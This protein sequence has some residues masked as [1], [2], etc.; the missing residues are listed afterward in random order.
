[1][2]AS[3]KIIVSFLLCVV[4]FV[5]FGCSCSKSINVESVV[6]DKEYIE[7]VVGEMYKLDASVIP[8]N[9]SNQALYYTDD[10][11][12]VNNNGR[13]YILERV[14]GDTIMGLNPGES[15]VTAMSRQDTSKTADITVRVFPEE[16]TLD[17]PSGL[18]YN[19]LTRRVEWQPV[20]YTNG[21]YT[22]SPSGYIVSLNGVEQ[23]ITGNTYFDAFESG[24]VNE[25]AV[26]A[27]GTS[28]VIHDS[29]FSS[30]IT[31]KRL[32]APTDIV[33]TGNTVSWS[34][35]TD[36]LSYTI[37]VN[38]EVFI[39]DI[40]D[41][42]ATVDFD[43]AGNYS[44]TVEAV[45]D[46]NT[47]KTLYPSLPSD[48]ISIVKLDAISE[49]SIRDS[50]L[51]WNEVAGAVEY[52][53]VFEVGDEKVQ[54]SAGVNTYI[55]L[56]NILEIPAGEVSASV[57]A[58]NNT[59]SGYDSENNVKV[60]FTKLATPN[61][62]QIENN[63]LTFSGSNNAVSYSID[64]NGEVSDLEVGVNYSLPSDAPAG[65]Y[66]IKLRANGNGTTTINSNWTSDENVFNAVKLPA[67]TS[68][69]HTNDTI[70]VNAV[71]GASSYEYK[72]IEAETDTVYQS[73]EIE[74]SDGNHIFKLNVADKVDLMQLIESNHF[75]LAVKAKGANGGNYFDSDY[76]EATTSFYKL[77]PP[78]NFSYSSVGE[79]YQFTWSLANGILIGKPAEL[80]NSVSKG[81]RPD[82]NNVLQNYFHY[83]F[84]FTDSEG[85]EL[86]TRLVGV[87]AD[88]TLSLDELTNVGGG[89]IYIAIALVGNDNDVITSSYSLALEGRRMYEPQNVVV[90]GT[91]LEFTTEGDYDDSRYVAVLVGEDDTE[92]ILGTT[93]EK[94]FDLESFVVNEE[95]FDFVSGTE[96]DLK[97]YTVGTPQENS[98]YYTSRFTYIT[99]ERLSSPVIT[100][101]GNYVEWNK[102]EN[103]SG[104]EVWIDGAK[105]D[106]I[107]E[108]EGDTY[109]SFIDSAEGEHN[110]IVYAISDLENNTY[111]KSKASN[112]LT[113]TRLLVEGL[114]IDNNILSWNKVLDDASYT[115]NVLNPE[116][117]EVVKTHT[118]NELSYDIRDFHLEGGVYN[119]AVIANHNDFVSS[120]DKTIIGFNV[121]KAP[122]I[123]YETQPTNSIISWQ[124]VSNAVGYKLAIQYLVGEEI[125][126][127]YTNVIKATTFDLSDKQVAGGV[128]T[129]ITISAIGDGKINIDSIYYDIENPLDF[130][131]LSTP[132]NIDGNVN[133]EIY[134]LSWDAIEGAKY[135][136]YLD[137]SKFGEAD[138]N[139]FGVMLST[140]DKARDY[141]FNVRAV[142]SDNSKPSSS[143]SDDF[144]VT[145]YSETTGLTVSDN[146]LTWDYTNN[147]QYTV[148]IYE[149]ENKVVEEIVSTDNFDLTV[150]ESGVYKAVVVTEGN[151]KTTI[152]G[153]A[154]EIDNIEVLGGTNGLKLDAQNKY[155][156]WTAT[157]NE[158]GYV[159]IYTQ[160]QTTIRQSAS[161]NYAVIPLDVTE[162]EWTVAVKVAGDGEL[163]V[164][165]PISNTITINKLPS[166]TNVSF[167]KD[168]LTFAQVEDYDNYQILIIID[169]ETNTY[170]FVYDVNGIELT[171]DAS[172]EYEIGVITVGDYVQNVSSNPAIVSNIL[173]LDTTERFYIQNNIL[174][175][176]EVNNATGYVVMLNDQE[177]SVSTNQFDLTTLG[178]DKGTYSVKVKA[179]STEVNVLD[180]DFVSLESDITVLGVVSNVAISNNSTITFVTTDVGDASGYII[181]YTGTGENV[182]SDEFDT[183]DTITINTELTSDTYTLTVVA[184]GNGEYIVNGKASSGVTITKPEAPNQVTHKSQNIAVT[185]SEGYDNYIIKITYED[186]DTFV[187]VSSPD[188]STLYDFT[189]VGDYTVSVAIKGDSTTYINSDYSE[190]ITVTRLAPVSGLQVVN[191]TITFD[192]NPLVTFNEFEYE[193]VFVGTTTKTYTTKLAQFTISDE[194]LADTFEIRVRCLAGDETR[195]LPS[196]YESVENIVKLEAPVI[197]DELVNNKIVWTA[198][199]VGIV[200]YEVKVVI[201]D[202]TELVTI[203]DVNTREFELTDKYVAGEYTISVR[204][205]GDG[206]SFV[207]SNFSNEKVVQ[208]LVAPVALVEKLTNDSTSDYAIKWDAVANATGYN[209]IIA[210]NVVYTSQTYISID[211]LEYTQDGL[212]SAKVIAVGDTEQYVNSN[213]SNEVTF[214]ITDGD[215][216]NIRLSGG[217]LVWEDVYG[218]V[219]YVLDINGVKVNVGDVTEYSLGTEFQAGDYKVSLKAYMN[220][221]SGTSNV[222]VNSSYS[223]AV[224]GYKLARPSSPDIIQ[225]FFKLSEVTYKQPAESGDG[226]EGEEGG[227]IVIIEPKY[228]EYEYG[229]ARNYISVDITD[230]VYSTMYSIQSNKVN[231]KA[232]F[233]YRAVGDDLNFTSDWSDAVSPTVGV[234]LASPTN[235]SMSNGLLTWD[236]VDHAS[237]YYVIGSY[238]Y[239]DEEGEM[240]VE[241]LQVITQTTSYLKPFAELLQDT[242]I[243]V[244][245]VVVAYGDSYYTNSM[246]SAVK[247]ITYLSAPNN[248]KTDKGVLTWEGGVNA[249]EV[250]IDNAIVKTIN[251]ASSYEFL[252]ESIGK[253][254]IKVKALGDGG[255]IVDSGYSDNQTI[256]K[257]S[258]PEVGDYDT[259]L[260]QGKLHWCTSKDFA[261]GLN[262]SIINAN[263]P[264][265][266]VRVYA[267]Y[268]GVIE[269]D[270]TTGEELTEE[271]IEAL[272]TNIIEF[273]NVGQFDNTNEYFMMLLN[274]YFDSLGSGSYTF[275]IAN[276]GN[277]VSLTDGVGYIT[278][279]YSAEF[280]VEILKVTDDIYIEDGVLHWNN[281]DNNNGYELFVDQGSDNIL[282]VVELARN[283]NSYDLNELQ[284]APDTY[285]IY[286]RTK[287]DSTIY[288]TSNTSKKVTTTILNVPTSGEFPFTIIDGKI[289]WNAVS[290]ASGYYVEVVNTENSEVFRY[291]NVEF[292]NNDGV[293][294]YRLPESLGA[295]T[296]NLR[297]KALGDGVE[298]LDSEFGEYGLVEKLS[299]L[300][301]IGNTL[302]KLQWEISYFDTNKPVDKYEIDLVGVNNNE[303]YT[304]IVSRSNGDFITD[305]EYCYYEL[306]NEVLQGTYNI[307]IRAVGD[308]VISDTSERLLYA[309]SSASYAIQATRLSAP[310]E[311]Y[312]DGGII[313]WNYTG[314]GHTGFYLVINGVTYEDNLI[315][316]QQSEF[317]DE[318][319]SDKHNLAVKVVGNTVPYNENG[320]RLLTSSAIGSELII[321][322]LNEVQGIMIY[323]G[324]IYFDPVENATEYEVVAKFGDSTITARTSAYDTSFG[325]YYF[326][327]IGDNYPQGEYESISVRAIGD[328]HY[329]NSKFR[330]F[331]YTFESVTY[332]NVFKLNTPRQVEIIIDESEYLNLRWQA[333]EYNFNDSNIVTTKYRIKL[334]GDGDY[335][336]Y[337]EF[338]VDDSNVVDGIVG[339]THYQIN[340]N[341]LLSNLLTGSYR[342]SLQALPLPYAED[343]YNALSSEYTSEIQITKPDTPSNLVFDTSLRAF[344]WDE[345]AIASGISLEYEVFYMYRAS[346]SATPTLGK[347][348]VDSPIFYP[349][350]L[351]IY[352]IA[353]R[354]IV[355]NSLASSYIG[356]NDYEPYLIIRRDG[357]TAQ[358]EL[359]NFDQID[360]IDGRYYIGDTEFSIVNM[361]NGVSGTHD[362]FAGGNGSVTD[363]YQISTAEQFGRMSFYYTSNFYFVQMNDINF[364]DGFYSVGTR[365]KPFSGTYDGGN[366]SIYNINATVNDEN[367]GLF[368]A[369]SGATIQNIRLSNSTLS[370]NRLERT[371][372]GF[373]VG[374]ATSTRVVNCDVTN[375]NIN[376]GYAS[377]NSISYY[378][379]GLVGYATG[380][381]S[382]IQDCYNASNIVRTNNST[383]LIM[384]SGGI[385]GYITTTN[386]TGLGIVNCGNAGSITGTLVGGLSGYVN[387][388]ISNSYNLGTVYGTY[389]DNMEPN[390][391]GL[392]GRILSTSGVRYIV[393]NSYNIGSVT[394]R[395][396]INGNSYA[397]GLAGRANCYVYNFYNAG[398]VLA[399][400][401][402]TSSSGSQINGWLIGSASDTITISNVYTTVTTL[403]NP[404]GSGNY[405]GMFE[406]ITMSSLGANVSEKLGDAF[407]Y[408]ATYG[409]VILA[410]ELN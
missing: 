245:V 329:V 320:T 391:G 312:V 34:S 186:N 132:T 178:L 49:L 160:G 283:N 230:E 86:Y 401:V 361:I 346:I 41:T 72:D 135:E 61:N 260:D 196:T 183:S 170:D 359:Y 249:Y 82:G 190:A 314:S 322:K 387:S 205:L 403:A 12:T 406:V 11:A 222:L 62:M 352:N 116:S 370:V 303:H 244:N 253:H 305:N 168:T 220:S 354:A 385:V 23:P 254:D 229:N 408:S 18:T 145:K 38:G 58:V 16:V 301:R 237:G 64:V 175:W 59:T 108:N 307:T 157:T 323:N 404:I 107:I 192:A 114:S 143:M 63:A 380:S 213:N 166:V 37:R 29:A 309:S 218:A 26:K 103:A 267:Y 386:D 104:Y 341:E 10:G 53:A 332:T 77:L 275:K 191:N 376:V 393:N 239:V 136:I 17:A 250:T 363:P 326:E 335:I 122:S 158:N 105:V 173:K 399:T 90:N 395:A 91:T 124:A 285:A 57:I 85:N 169:G 270:D 306:N 153:T 268:N 299:T 291:D 187:E 8:S 152:S 30:S 208:K 45:P 200:G 71:N 398:E 337:Y 298:Y 366:Y 233:R 180:S 367:F 120:S 255:F 325:K 52:I 234:Q 94:Y 66:A 13:D 247:T 390:A 101:N 68:V 156:T 330:E 164:E 232:N 128:V 47:D 348:V 405:S 221:Q 279:N 40:T 76:S 310:T 207:R 129:K 161:E 39:T 165:S 318:I 274:E 27:V 172:G 121:L 324:V 147:A 248:F 381:G 167:N 148:R 163:K 118:T 263:R 224:S 204:A 31:V 238:S 236:K 357:S 228:F 5:T 265:G 24:V 407:V 159:V 155:L 131:K 211:E 133:D 262:Q 281:M 257:L 356:A 360:I 151:G 69:S 252:T 81:Q 93:T 379:G 282:K 362:L 304:F 231:T 339:S 92:T 334:V 349:A 296:Y 194:L 378:I 392:A 127:D 235:V 102:V 154:T 210:G 75:T 150:L 185:A 293:I 226:S 87:E 188:L 302:G 193:I 98:P 195:Y 272:R 84:T 112:T 333:V 297:I 67:P 21:S 271:E 278:S 316:V 294:T 225:G 44:V 36:A 117:G 22:Y 317:R 20:T 79:G 140:F 223:D 256:Y 134:T 89:T 212:N 171:F 109:R 125:V 55:G 269:S 369:T 394:S 177:Y 409:R 340:L 251:G 42:S 288:L 202:T 203:T 396:K 289:S 328:S 28:D 402:G 336:R 139:S 206:I 14:S 242:T 273:F 240:Q 54:K 60:T 35:V 48:A 51:Y 280:N 1:M 149:G 377:S 95:P 4:A 287:G 138:T 141:I 373:I 292:E 9:A 119:I 106:A 110:I 344:T 96:Y 266:N 130:T 308:V 78:V 2:G 97:L 347:T 227:G 217:K 74:L 313:K 327:L 198:S 88:E 113:I 365:E 345:P 219:L 174:H 388:V 50:A 80:V 144:V 284:L 43:V 343:S 142:S 338:E 331:E 32:N 258:A 342:I 355:S 181:I 410:I 364:A 176:S 46:T 290:G 65:D 353:V 276:M 73:G 350:E 215:A 201:G 261:T 126:T 315:T 397:G 179:V 146:K 241:Q 382:L 137:G 372:V 100:R 311:V 383:S 56:N 7:I 246:N 259:F 182:Y 115:L 111:I 184:K 33:R 25:V 384:Y 3:K 319:S 162:G 214:N 374:Y 389:A 300:T 199:Q 295:G 243:M 264:L 321:E 351:G 368:K 99:V 277:S 189:G 15:V 19:T 371:N 209:V 83:L 358:E 6:W 375:S 286:V 123:I 400:S 216:S 70:I 197:S